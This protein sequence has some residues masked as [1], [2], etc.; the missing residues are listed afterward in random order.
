MEDT[1]IIELFWNRD[2]KAIEETSGKY[3]K[4]CKYIAINI[5]K[6]EQEAE[7]IVN[8][9]MFGVWNSIPP[10]RPT[11]FKAFLCKV[12]KNIA[13]TRAK[14]INAEKRKPEYQIALEEIGDVLSDNE[15]IEEKYELQEVTD[16]MNEYLKGIDKIKRIIFVKRY[17][18]SE[19]VADISNE[20]G[21][22]ESMVKTTLFRVRRDMKKYLEKKGVVL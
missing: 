8:E 20:L 17:W 16:I 10:N 11:Y 4:L 19:S 7:E 14:Y 12:T 5:L 3:G 6:D 21:L 13:M 22:S 1:K 18:Y 9:T 2:Q 15:S